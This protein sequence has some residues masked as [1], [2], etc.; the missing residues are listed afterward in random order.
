MKIGKYLG[1]P[2]GDIYNTPHQDDVMWNIDKDSPYKKFRGHELKGRTLG[3]IG[4]G[5]IGRRVA[6]FVIV[7]LQKKQ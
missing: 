7:R 6:K 3:L 2:I 1:K 4:L 5:N